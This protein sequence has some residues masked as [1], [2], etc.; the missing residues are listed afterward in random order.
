MPA[1]IKKLI[2]T[3]LILVWMFFYALFAMRLSLAV[4]PGAHWAV[5]LFYYVFA[6]VAWIVPAGFLIEWMSKDPPSAS[7]A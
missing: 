3:V 1:R 6:G 2:G 7:G 4:L 5:E